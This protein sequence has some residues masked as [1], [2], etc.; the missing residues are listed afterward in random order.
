MQVKELLGFDT[1]AQGRTV[2][3]AAIP[4]LHAGLYLG[5]FVS[6]NVGKCNG[7]GYCYGSLVLEN[8]TNEQQK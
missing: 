3:N 6:Q 7:D 4:H 8:L 2:Q 5:G 1:S